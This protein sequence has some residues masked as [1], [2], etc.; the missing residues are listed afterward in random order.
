M[1]V[2]ATRGAVSGFVECGTHVLPPFQFL[3]EARYPARFGVGPRG[4]PQDP[5]EGAREPA[6]IAAERLAGGHCPARLAHER[7]GGIGAV[8]SGRMAAPAGAKSLALGGFGDGEKC[9][10]GA[11]RAAAGARGAAIDAGRAD[12]VHERP[13]EPAISCQHRVPALSGTHGGE[14]S[15]SPRWT[16]IRFVRSNPHCHGSSLDGP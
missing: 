6:R 5:L 7:D 3:F 8:G 4:D 9:D 12:G 16:S 15:A 11:P 1:F 10:L 14:F 13:V 2:D